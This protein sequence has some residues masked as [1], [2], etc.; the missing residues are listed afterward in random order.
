MRISK[1]QF[2]AVYFLF[3]GFFL[4]S[5]IPNAGFESW[6]GNVPDNWLTNSIPVYFTTITKS[7][8]AHSGSAAV[9]GDVALF[10]GNNV[11]PILT[12]GTEGAGSGFSQRPKSFS[13]WY[14]LNSVGGDLFAFNVLLM[15]GGTE[16]GGIAMTLPAAS[17][18]TKAS[19]DVIY[20]TDDIPDLCVI[21][22]MIV[23][24]S[25]LGNVHAGSYFITDD[26]AFEGTATGVKNGK[27]LPADFSLKQNFPNPFNPNTVIEFSIPQKS[28]V[29]LSVYNLIGQ[30]VAELVNKTMEPGIHKAV[31][32]AVNMTSGVYFYKLEAGSFT[33]TKKMILAR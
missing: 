10:M 23:D 14:K 20:L 17:S 19:A 22:L 3:S 32:N 30:K 9:K 27:S 4:Y 31:F 15:K 7:G 2:A 25:M 33:N 24:N 29:K 8:D 16:V 12:S 28:N 6:N 1:L 26:V 11:P 13:C 18:Y 21:Q 5:Q